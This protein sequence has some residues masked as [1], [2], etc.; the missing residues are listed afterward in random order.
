MWNLFPLYLFL[1]N[2]ISAITYFFSEILVGI[3]FRNLDAVTLRAKIE[4]L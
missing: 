1:K 4:G 3:C 2:F